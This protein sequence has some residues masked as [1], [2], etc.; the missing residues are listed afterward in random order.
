M[1][2]AAFLDTIECPLEEKPL[3]FCEPRDRDPASELARVKAFRKLFRKHF[4]GARLVAIP[5]G[6]ER[7]QWQLNLVRS[8]G[9]AWGFFDLLAIGAAP[10]IAIMEWKSGTG[11]LRP[12]QVAWG[13]W[14]QRRGHLVGMFRKPETAVAWLFERG[15]RG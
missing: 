1:L 7:S 11:A 12:H 10:W 13:N 5:N 6:G 9:A 14:L 15:F 4:P 8:E 3:F 2:D